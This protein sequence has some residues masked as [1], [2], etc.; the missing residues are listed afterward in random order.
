MIAGIEHPRMG[1]L[2]FHQHQAP[3]LQSAV[4]DGRIPA[5]QLVVRRGGDEV[6]NLAAGWLDPDTRHCT[7]QPD[8]LFDIASITKLFTG[9]SFMTLV[10][11]GAV[12]LDQSV[13]AVLPAFNGERPIQ[14]YEDPLNPGQTMTVSKAAGAV[15][16]GSV[17]FCHLLTH[18]SGLPA[19]RPLYQQPSA[20]AARRMALE[21][22]F[23]YPPGAQ[24]VY[25]DVGFILLGMAIEQLTGQSLET[26]VHQR[27]IA[28]LKLQHT[29]YFH[30]PPSGSPLQGGEYVSIRGK[31]S[32]PPAGGIEGGNIAPTE[33]CRWR[34]RRIIGQVHDENA[35]RLGGAAGHAG[36]FSTATDLATLGQALLDCKKGNHRG[37]PLR[38]ETV[39]EMTRLQ[40]AG[41]G[42]RRGLGF[43]LWQPDPE[44]S[45]HPFSQQAFGHLGFTGASLWI[46]PSYDLVVALLTNE[47]YNGRQ[48]RQI[49]P[50][51]ISIHKAM[52]NH[53]S[54]I[55]NHATR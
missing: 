36:L 9:L 5:A 21:T 11:E 2:L 27:V 1:P 29:R 16:V 25:S 26:A 34:G 30:T 35:Y 19:W 53:E 13:G 40:T 4:T 14:P 24:V 6:L 41:L 50:L 20:D 55:T 46:D 28:P 22:F 18:T 12:A 23:S 10:Q 44:S 31:A 3:A 37:L 45:S 52:M 51:R 33:F 47:V 48:N 7:T 43:M 49:Q 17:T 32:L 54:R 8:T 42:S 39:D 38:A 15:D